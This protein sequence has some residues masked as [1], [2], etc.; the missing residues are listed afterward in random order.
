MRV[1]FVTYAEKTHFFTMIP[2][3]W[4]LQTAGHEVRVASQVELAETITGAGLAAVPVGFSDFHRMVKEAG[5]TE[6]QLTDPAHDL[7]ETDREKMTWDFMLGSS[8]VRVPQYFMIANNRSMLTELVAYAKHWK[9]DLIV[10]EP[11]SFSG[12]VAARISGAAHARLV[13]SPDVL[14]NGRAVFRELAAQQDPDVQDDP[15]GEWLQWAVELFGGEYDEEVATGAFDIDVVPP[16][17]RLPAYD[18]RPV[19]STRYIPYNGPAVLPDWLMVPP[20]KPRVCLSMGITSNIS[21]AFPVSYADVLAA[22]ADLDVEIVATVPKRLQDELPAVPDNVRLT[23][24]VP[25][26]PLLQQCSAIIHHGGT[27][28]Q[29]TAV[30]HGVPQLLVPW[31]FDTVLKGRLLA[32]SGAGLTIPRDEVT[33]EG[34]R[35]GL[36]RLLTEPE[37]AAAA[38]RV[39][40]E[41]RAMPSPNEVVPVLEKLT[42]EYRR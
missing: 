42:S 7:A 25:L 23:D 8:T 40:D 41:T 34:L 32:E 21:N 2:L 35:T 26:N 28:T 22:T 27:G 16:A 37:F 5:D 29:W 31:Q 15:L 30:V 3:A 17:F 6:I 24:F 39:R 11:F 38:G 1:L 4:A 36:E 14:G 13:W 12:A 19:V 9:P 18:R 20:E 33:A 10:W